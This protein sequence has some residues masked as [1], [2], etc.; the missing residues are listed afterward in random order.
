METCPKEIRSLSLLLNRK[1]ARLSELEN[2]L[3]S[4]I[5]KAYFPI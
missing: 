5:A 1:R 3:Q 4:M 2:S